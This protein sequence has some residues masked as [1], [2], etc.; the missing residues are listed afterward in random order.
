MAA[1]MAVNMKARSNGRRSQ[2]K[3]EDIIRRE[4]RQI[5]QRY[6]PPHIGQDHVRLWKRPAPN[7]HRKRYQIPSSH[8]QPTPT[9]PNGG[10]PRDAVRAG[11]DRLIKYPAKPP[12]INPDT[13]PTS[14]KYRKSTNG[15]MSASTANFDVCPRCSRLRLPRPTRRRT[16]PHS[17]R[18]A[19]AAADPHAERPAQGSMYWKEPP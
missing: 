9:R 19:N 7:D 5:G 16:T 15:S 2:R 6:R 12:T 14:Q 17:P 1:G 11:A 18:T 8:A 3:S 10:R 13:A 4:S